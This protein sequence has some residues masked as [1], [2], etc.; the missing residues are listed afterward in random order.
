MWRVR[1]PNALG[2]AAAALVTLSVRPAAATVCNDRCLDLACGRRFPNGI[3][4]RSVPTNVRVA[5][6]FRCGELFGQDVPRFPTF[7]TAA[8]QPIASNWVKLGE[9]LG[10]LG[11]SG[12]R[13]VRD[14]PELPAN[15]EIV[16]S[17]TWSGTCV[18]ALRS[19]SCSSSS[20][21]CGAVSD[22]GCCAQTP[23][24]D[25][26]LFRFNTTTRD[27]QPTSSTAPRLIIRESRSLR[28]SNRR[29]T[30]A[31]RPE[32]PRRM[33]SAFSPT[34][35][36]P[37]RTR[38]PRASLQRP[39][40][41]PRPW[42]LD[43]RLRA[44]PTHPHRRPSRSHPWTGVHAGA[45]WDG[46]PI[47]KQGPALRFSRYWWSFGVAGTATRTCRTGSR[48]LGRRRCRARLGRLLP[49]DCRP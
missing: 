8:G 1:P 18:A 41:F 38:S 3:A 33:P 45:S 37:S 35:S 43:K 17:D 32:R 13:F 7:S 42:T 11:V 12:A 47:A 23:G 36:A 2:V 9:A 49:S 46:G 5:M 48:C 24:A 22:G 26:E 30:Q 31:M 4:G 25:R 29:A 14:G 44:L 15:T 28:A 39:C 16:A 6:D 20:V 27:D 21:S 10:E 40:P 19:T 34:R